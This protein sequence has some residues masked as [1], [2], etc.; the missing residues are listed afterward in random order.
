MKDLH[1][2]ILTVTLSLLLG[3][4]APICAAAQPQDGL[5]SDTYTYV[6]RDSA[7]LLD[8]YKPAVPREDKAAV[9]SL[10]GGGF[11][12]GERNNALSKEIAKSLTDRGYTVISIDYR[13]GFRDRAKVAENSIV[14]KATG[15]FRYCTGSSGLTVWDM[16]S[17]TGCPDRLTCSAHSRN[18]HWQ[19]G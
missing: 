18:S 13:L 15:L 12:M 9:I 16:R 10:F 4:T 17:P 1:R 5:K 14:F 3:L 19:A 8:V 7:L 2:T 6:Q 11:F